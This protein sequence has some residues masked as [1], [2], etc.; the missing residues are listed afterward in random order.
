MYKRASYFLQAMGRRAAANSKAWIPRAY[1]PRT[2]PQCRKWWWP[3]I[4]YHSKSGTN[5]RSAYGK[6]FPNWLEL[7]VQRL[8]PEVWLA[9]YERKTGKRSHE[10][11]AVDARPTSTKAAP[12]D[13][14]KHPAGKTK[15]NNAVKRRHRDPATIQARLDRRMVGVEVMVRRG[16]T[17]YL[18]S[19]D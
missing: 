12:T 6:R 19:R 3:V 8:T 11:D 4:E 1:I 18:V 14:P 16:R 17:L 10:R 7:E 13:R 2:K 5:V 15:R 9:S